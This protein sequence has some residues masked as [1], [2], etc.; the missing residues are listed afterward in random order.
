M[1]RRAKPKEDEEDVVPHPVDDRIVLANL[2]GE[3]EIDPAIAKQLTVGITDP[4]KRKFIL[5]LSILGNRSR[6][7]RAVGVSPMVPWMWRKQDDDGHF[8]KAYDLAMKCA[9][10]LHEDELYRRASEGVL[11]PVFQ[12][13][14]LVGSIRKYSDTL[15]IFML[16]GSMPDK[17]GDKTKVEHSGS[18]DVASRLRAARERVFKRNEEKKR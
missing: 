13:G 10:D 14:R 16:K 18:I 3:N 4:K 12:G 9:A 7:A 11:E 17:Y 15:L 6:A 2:L 1:P 8:S 5:A